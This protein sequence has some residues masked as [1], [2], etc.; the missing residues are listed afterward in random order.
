LTIHSTPSARNTKSHCKSLYHRS[1]RA[2]DDRI[3]DAL[4]R[5]ILE[6]VKK[7]RRNDIRAVDRCLRAS[8][9]L[10]LPARLDADWK[11]KARALAWQPS[12][13]SIKKIFE[14]FARVARRG[15]ERA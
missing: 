10:F 8:V 7:S 15:D 14:R 2:L 9:F 5:Q 11:F 13:C 3:V 1:S 6:D 12:F 4:P